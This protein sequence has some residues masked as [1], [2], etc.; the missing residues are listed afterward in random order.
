MFDV[1]FVRGLRVD[2]IIGVLAHER[3]TAQTICIDLQMH[4]QTG[5]AAA[6]DQ[7]VDALD[8]ATITNAVVDLTRAAQFNLVETLAENIAELILANDLVQAVTV[9]VDKPQAMAN[10]DTVGVRIHRER[11]V[12]S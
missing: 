8:Y 9:S 11:K 1:V 12:D 6:S 7:L 2:A 5:K 10:T 3:T 4:V